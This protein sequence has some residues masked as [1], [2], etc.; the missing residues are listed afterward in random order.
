MR[1]IENIL[2][3]VAAIL[4][5]VIFGFADNSNMSHSAFE[6]L[7]YG[8]STV[9]ILMVINGVIRVFYL[10]YRKINEWWVGNYDVGE[11]G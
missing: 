6:N 4:T 10:T 5:L 1:I 3:I 7:G 9:F 8:L 11:N 2:L